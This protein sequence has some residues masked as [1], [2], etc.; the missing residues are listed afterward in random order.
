VV[1]GDVILADTSPEEAASEEVLPEDATSG[2]AV[3]ADVV[4]ATEV[5]EELT[6]E[7]IVAWLD[8]VPEDVFSTDGVSTNR[9][10]EVVVSDS[11]YP[12]DVDWVDVGSDDEDPVDAV[13]VDG[14]L[15]RTLIDS[16]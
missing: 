15:P 10:P 1:P 7:A 9:V 5:C 2:N 6:S 3:S 12:C 11:V 16:V 13:S 14:S 8:A 4:L